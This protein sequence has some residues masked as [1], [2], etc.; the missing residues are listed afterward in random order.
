MELLH[1]DASQ[2]TPVG[3]ALLHAKQQ[4]LLVEVLELEESAALLGVTDEGKL[5]ELKEL[6]LDIISMQQRTL[7]EEAELQAVNKKEKKPTSDAE[8][9]AKLAKE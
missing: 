4:E 1:K 9:A 7:C 5:D 2:H 3:L 8:W 6:K